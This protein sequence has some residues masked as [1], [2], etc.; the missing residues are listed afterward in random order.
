ML[1]EKLDTNRHTILFDGYN[2]I[3]D[4]DNGRVTQSLSNYDTTQTSDH[5]MVIFACNQLG[6]YKYHSIMKLYSCKVYENGILIM[7]LIPCKTSLNEI[8]MYDTVNYKFY[9]NA[10]TGEFVPGDEV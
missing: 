9:S 6:I 3:I 10:G 2:K 1:N 7:N 8:G 4:L 5:E